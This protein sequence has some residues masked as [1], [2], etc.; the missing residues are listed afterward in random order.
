MEGGAGALSERHCVDLAD[1]SL[2]RTLVVVIV[3]LDE[4]SE[5]ELPVASCQLPVALKGVAKRLIAV[6]VEWPND[7]IKLASV[8]R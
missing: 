5:S 7:I 4:A 1:W 6:P 2:G 8:A 3:R